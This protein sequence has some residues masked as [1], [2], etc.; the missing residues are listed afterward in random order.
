MEAMTLMNAEEL[1]SKYG[2]EILNNSSGWSQSSDTPTIQ[3]CL[4]IL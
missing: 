1:T 4:Y 2:L 3:E